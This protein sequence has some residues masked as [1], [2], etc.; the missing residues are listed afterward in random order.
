MTI[1]SG[2]VIVQ[3]GSDTYYSMLAFEGTTEGSTLVVR[4]LEHRRYCGCC[5]HS[6][7]RYSGWMP[8]DAVKRGMIVKATE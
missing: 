3:I 1:P 5:G 2:A 4:F 7:D 6:Q 8:F